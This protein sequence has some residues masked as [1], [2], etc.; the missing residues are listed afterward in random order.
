MYHY[1]VFVAHASADNDLA[2]DVLGV[3]GRMRLRPLSDHNLPPA[4]D[5]IDQIQSLIGRSHLFMPILTRNSAENLWVHEEIGYALG[6]GIPVLPLKTDE[7]YPDKMQMLTLRQA[8]TLPSDVTRLKQL[9]KPKDIDSLVIKKGK[10]S[11]LAMECA[12]NA[13]A[14]TE[15]IAA[16][17][18]WTGRCRVR[19]RAAL[20]AFS[21]PD[22]H[23]RDPIWRQRDWDTARDDEF[24]E[25][26]RQERV[27]LEQHARRSGCDLFI[28]PTVVYADHQK[29]ALHTR[30]LVLRQFLESMTDRQVRVAMGEPAREGN[31]TIVGDWF[32]GET[33]SAWKGFGC[34]QSVFTWHAPRVYQKIREFD[35]LFS[36]YYDP[37][38]SPSSR[39]RAIAKITERIRSL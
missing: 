9:L 5:F 17:D 8:V 19:Q 20:S 28:D 11:R 14:R 12:D 4:E 33:V 35:R 23:P 22:A 24:H 38:P 32:Y 15:Q 29:G 37:S 13:K 6:A 31:L 2:D 1:R 39:E 21:I 3:L 27:S 25:L 10:D 7:V 30:L 26:Q 16:G 18:R 34:V 36:A